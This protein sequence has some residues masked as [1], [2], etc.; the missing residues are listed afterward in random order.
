MDTRFLES[1]VQVVELGSIAAAARALDLTPTAV[2][3][4]LKALEAEV[5]TAL[6][7]RAGRTVQPTQAGG[8]VLTQARLLLQEVKNFNSLASSTELPAGPLVLGATPSALK[9]M[10]LPILQRWVEKYPSIEVLIEPGPSTTLYERVMSGVLDAA[11]LVHPLF[12]VPKTVS[13]KTLRTERLILLTPSGLDH[14]DPFAIIRDYP[15]IRYDRRVV[16]GKMADDYLRTNKLYPTARLE[17]DGIDYIAD[18]VKAGLG[19]SVLPDWADGN[20][21]DPALTRH[22]LPEP[23][24]TRELGLLWLRTNAREKLVRAFLDL[25]TPQP[26]SPP[27]QSRKSSLDS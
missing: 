13:W 16:A 22:R 26:A 2:S 27:V 21:L 23:V 14:V 20:R 18:M 1:F 7:E 8:K 11:I 4:R 12:D 10:L 9:G 24:P 19:V 3:L 17:L 15:Y 5:G 25:A 6:V